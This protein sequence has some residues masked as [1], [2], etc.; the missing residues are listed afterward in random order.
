M[1]LSL[2]QSHNSL[3]DFC[4]VCTATFELTVALGALVQVAWN[5]TYVFNKLTLLVP[6]T[7]MTKNVP[8]MCVY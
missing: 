7:K 8:C 5:I 6:L 2:T 1:I 3:S 4:L